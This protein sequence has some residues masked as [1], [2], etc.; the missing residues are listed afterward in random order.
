M[1]AN[2]GAI[3]TNRFFTSP[4]LS[5]PSYSPSFNR[6]VMCMSSVVYSIA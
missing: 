6:I 4:T 1:H 2:V 3:L 5:L